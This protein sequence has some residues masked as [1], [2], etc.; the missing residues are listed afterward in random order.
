[1][2]TVCKT[3]AGGVGTARLTAPV[4]D[5]PS[6]EGELKSDPSDLKRGLRSMRFMR[7]E[8]AAEMEGCAAGRGIAAR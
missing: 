8:K 1:M 3:V 6:E 2:F 5:S 7:W 4:K